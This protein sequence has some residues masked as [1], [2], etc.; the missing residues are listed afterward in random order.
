MG[1]TSDNKGIKGYELYPHQFRPP[2]I[3]KHS[4]LATQQTDQNS[5]CWKQRA[6]CVLQGTVFSF[7]IRPVDYKPTKV[8]LDY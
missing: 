1:T 5:V 7:E 3:F 2:S 6:A 4:Y 8:G